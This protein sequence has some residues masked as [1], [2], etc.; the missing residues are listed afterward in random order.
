L[1]QY[2]ACRAPGTIKSS[3]YNPRKSRLR[4]IT[5]QFW[6]AESLSQTLVAV[7]VATKKPQAIVAMRMAQGFN[8]GA[9]SA[10]RRTSFTLIFHS[11]VFKVDRHC[12]G[13]NSEQGFNP[14]P[15]VHIARKSPKPSTKDG[16][17][18][19]EQGCGF[20]AGRTPCPNPSQCLF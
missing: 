2:C 5:F 16:P 4:S 12:S 14:T 11:H 8:G 9:N 17:G 13:A 10:F 19:S 15:Q 6:R 20:A 18:L 7:L 1:R 3:T